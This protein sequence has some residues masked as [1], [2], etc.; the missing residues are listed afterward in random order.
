MR[1]A[2]PAAVLAVMCALTFPAVRRASL[3]EEPRMAKLE[4]IF[5]RFND[6]K[7]PGIAILVRKAGRTVF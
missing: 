4:E 7:S 6:A 5:A 3:A 2:Q 1:V